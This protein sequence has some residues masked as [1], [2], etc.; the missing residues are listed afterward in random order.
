MNPIGQ[1]K[2]NF[3]NRINSTFMNEMIKNAPVSIDLQTGEMTGK[4]LTLQRRTIGDLKDVFQDENARLKMPQDQLA[5]EVQL[6]LPV[7]EGTQGGLYFGN[8]TIYPGKVG[9]E[10]MMTK[11]HFH[12]T[13][14]RNE[15][16]LCVRGN[17]YLMF[18]NGKREARVE[19]MN[20]GSLH[21][22]GAHLAHRVIN[23]GNAPLTFLAS[24]PADAGHD[25]GSI[26]Q[27]GFA[28]RVIEENGKPNL[29]RV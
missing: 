8:T 22:I 9:K 19:P 10:Y 26:Q 17:G 13:G 24:W 15:Y 20:P 23:I 29:V 25:Y 4:G 21:Y 3:E 27:N 14:D 6:F 16:Y 5:Y 28:L 18:M 7:P 12:E 1:V 11:G 2:Y